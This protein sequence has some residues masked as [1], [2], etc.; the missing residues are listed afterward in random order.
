MHS[1]RLKTYFLFVFNLKNVLE[2]TAQEAARPPLTGSPGRVRSFPALGG[3]ETTLSPLAVAA[4]SGSGGH[5]GGAGAGSLS[6]GSVSGAKRPRT[7]TG[8]GQR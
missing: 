8:L 7:P 2:Q 6:G 1:N 3:R 5:E 4:S